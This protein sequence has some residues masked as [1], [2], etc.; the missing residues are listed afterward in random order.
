MHVEFAVPTAGD[1]IDDEAK[2]VK[3]GDHAK[4]RVLNK[5]LKISSSNE[6]VIKTEDGALTLGTAKFVDGK[7][8]KDGKEGEVYLDIAFNGDDDIF[9]KT[10]VKARADGEF[11]LDLS[12]LEPGQ[13]GEVVVATAD[14]EYKVKVKE[15][16][17]ELGIEKSGKI[18][19]NDKTVEW[20][21]KVSSNKGTLGDAVFTDALAD[22][23]EYV[24]KSI[25]VKYTLKGENDEKIFKFGENDNDTTYDQDTKVLSYKFNKED[26]K[27]VASPAII[28]FKTK[29]SPRQFT[30]I[31][32]NK[33]NGGGSFFET[34]VIEN[35][36]KI[37]K[38]EKTQEAKAKVEW[39]PK[40]A[41]KDIEEYQIGFKVRRVKIEGDYYISWNIVVNEEKA[42]LEDVKITEELAPFMTDSS[43][44]NTDFGLKLV[45]ATIKVYDKDDKEVSKEDHGKI[46]K[47]VSK[48]PYKYA[49][50]DA[51]KELPENNIFEVG[52]IDGKVEMHVTARVSKSE[53]FLSAL[54]FAKN[55]VH[56]AWKDQGKW[57][58]VVVNNTQITSSTI[59]KWSKEFK[60]GKEV[61]LNRY[62]TPY[63]ARYRFSNFD[64]QYE[65]TVNENDNKF[66]EAAKI[67]DAIV[68]D[69]NVV[70]A[71]FK[72]KKIT[73]G[74]GGETT[75]DGIDL[76][77]FVDSQNRDIMHQ[78]YDGHST[79]KGVIVEVKKLYR[80]DDYIGDLVVASKLVKGESIFID[81]HLTDSKLIVE[82]MGHPISEYEKEKYKNAGYS[83]YNTAVFADNV[84][85][86]NGITKF[87]VLEKLPCWT[88]YMSRM[89]E[90][91]ALTREAA[92]KFKQDKTVENAN[93]A[94]IKA[95]E[96][97]KAFD[98]NDKTVTYRLSVNANGVHDMGDLCLKDNLPEGWQLVEYTVFEGESE[99]KPQKGV[100][101]DKEKLRAMET[102]RVSATKLLVG[103]SG[104]DLNIDDNKL[105]AEYIKD[106]TPN[107][108]YSGVEFTFKNIDKPYVILLKAKPTDAKLEEY[109]KSKEKKITVKNKAELS[110]DNKRITR[111]QDIVLLQEKLSVL[112][113][114][115]ELLENKQLRWHIDYVPSGHIKDQDAILEDTLSNGIDFVQNSFKVYELTVKADGTPELGAD[116]TK[117]FKHTYEGKSLKITI[118][119]ENVEKPYRFY[120]N[121][122]VSV[123]NGEKVTNKVNLK[124]GDKESGHETQKVYVIGTATGSATATEPASLEIL[125]TDKADGK[126]LA[127]AVF[128]LK[129]SKEGSSYKKEATTGQAGKV[130]FANIPVGEYLLKEVTAPAG[131]KLDNKVYM[132]SVVAKDGTRTVEVS[133]VEM[134]DGKPVIKNGVISTVGKV[135]LKDGA[136]TVTN[137]KKP[138]DPPKPN[139][140]P[141]PDPKPNPNP[142]TYP[143]GRTPDPNDPASPPVITVIDENGVPLGN[144]EKQTKPDGTSEYVLI[145]EDVPLALLPKTGGN[146]MVPYAAAGVTLIIAGLGLYAFRRKKAE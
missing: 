15:P 47:E 129:S 72:E 62:V 5:G 17:E 114:E 107:G 37:T 9:A 14:K 85:N 87:Q 28:T 123:K 128:E 68:F 6:I 50:E 57:D 56:V 92:T 41:K 139:P 23:G 117:D 71:D 82:D 140:N 34:T 144:Y 120:Y 97:E 36:A 89:L 102:A 137:E 146:G 109:A 43:G 69:N 91:E 64:L 98:Y 132:V 51:N 32:H 113:K 135:E 130:K 21:V 73:V 96:K 12:G 106:E 44:E 115:L 26:D 121:T 127:G 74:K 7:D 52:T 60:D 75:I 141:N 22:V 101:S 10:G 125:K 77:Q 136:L 66:T 33:E 45:G 39:S 18:N 61:E 105:K 38:G 78:K 119:K 131:Y 88:H 55:T 25:E 145:D 13:G 86:G 59:S 126:L 122:T 100:I 27:S 2:I 40:W 116:V 46:V 90:K 142:P 4:V 11:K 31:R 19:K 95:N 1:G 3:K 24:S 111:E 104:E 83:F 143:N 35:T 84:T 8:V 20:T 54:K 80:G 30:A 49:I 94:V 63:D 112:N 42:H 93:G 81:T 58:V 79:K 133:E 16:E 99:Q 70:R 118:P 67:Y 48:N 134:K 108:F 65:I 103:K 29:M 76:L 110:L 124:V 138:S 53:G